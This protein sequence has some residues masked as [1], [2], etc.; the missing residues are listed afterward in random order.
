[1]AAAMLGRAAAPARAVRALAGMQA[2]RGARASSVLSSTPPA[3]YAIGLNYHAHAAE[4]GLPIPR[5]PI[6]FLKPPTS[7]IGPG[8]PIVIPA[9]CKPDEVDWEAELAVIIGRA[10]KDVR[11]A[12]ALDYVEGYTVGND[13]SARRWQGKKGGGQ[14]SRAKAFDTFCPLGPRVVPAAEIADPGNLNLSCTVN[15]VLM[16]E[17]STQ[18]MIF[19]VPQLIAF[20]SQGTTLLPGTV[21]LTGTPAGVGFTRKPPIYLKPGDVVTAAVEGIGELTNTVVAERG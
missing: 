14:W 5:F 11:E 7:V 4:T 9:V 2:V 19:S 20:L 17:S 16:Q 1:M 3:I 10:A 13:V 12:E 21:I 8:A 18:D 6:Y 15:G